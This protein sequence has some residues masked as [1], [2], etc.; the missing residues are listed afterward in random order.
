MTKEFF[1]ELRERGVKFFEDLREN[2]ENELNEF[3]FEMAKICKPININEVKLTTPTT[4]SVFQKNVD[5]YN[6]VNAAC[7]NR[8]LQQPRLQKR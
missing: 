8:S 4:V 7:S 2:N 5:L 3:K 1:T 6:D